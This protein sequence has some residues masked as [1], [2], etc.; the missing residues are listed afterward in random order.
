MCT[1][2]LQARRDDHRKV[3]IFV[4]VA[5]VDGFVDIAVLQR[6]CDFRSILTRLLSCL[7]VGKPTLD[8]DGD[9]VD[10]LDEQDTDNDPARN[11]QARRDVVNTE[12][13]LALAVKHEIK[14]KDRGSELAS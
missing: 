2:F 5:Y 14:A 13:N 1:E 10:R 9:H 4:L 11:R 12:R 6:L 3:R 7:V 8:T